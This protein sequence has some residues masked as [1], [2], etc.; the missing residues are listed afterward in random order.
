MITSVDWFQSRK[1]RMTKCIEWNCETEC[2][3]S[4]PAYCSHRYN[5][6]I[7]TK[8]EYD[9][10]ADNC[11]NQNICL[12]RWEMIVTFWI[13][14]GDSSYYFTLQHSMIVLGILCLTWLIITIIYEESYIHI[15]QTNLK[16][17]YPWSLP[18]AITGLAA[19]RCLWSEFDW[20]VLPSALIRK[21][22]R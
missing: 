20:I 3:F 16:N 4:K 6:W 7:V 17:V 8:N 15:Q 12:T 9:H 22:T 5:G 11:G 14:I 1:R 21:T 18:I 19:I 13:F 2:G 10:S